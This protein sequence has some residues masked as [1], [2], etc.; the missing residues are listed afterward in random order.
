METRRLII[1]ERVQGVAYRY[2]MTEEQRRRGFRLDEEPQRRSVEALV[3]GA[4]SVVAAIIA[5][6]RHGPPSAGVS[7]EAVELAEETCVGF[8]ERPSA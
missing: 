1:R 5:W 7:H 4:A 6:A 3:S 8:A 2:H